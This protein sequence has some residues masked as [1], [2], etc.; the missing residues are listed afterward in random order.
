VSEPVNDKEVSRSFPDGFEWGTAT[1]AHQIEGGNWNND[2]WAW[3]HRPGSGV[4]EPSGDA[5]DSWNRWQEDV[6]IVRNLGLGSYRFSIEWSR[7]E[8]EPGEWSQAALD[9]Y[10]RIGE[11]LRDEGIQPVVT[12]HHFSSPRWFADRG[13]WTAPNAA[14][15]FARFCERAARE[16]API[17]G[18]VCTINEPSVVAIMGYLMGM[19]P[20]GIS[21]EEEWRRVTDS[22]CGAHRKAVD[23]IRSAAPGVP[24][25]MALAMSDYQ[26]LEGGEEKLNEI[27]AMMEDVFLDATEGDDFVGVQ[28]YSR[29]RVGPHGWVGPEPGVPVLPLGYEY[30]PQA[31]AATIRRA[32]QYTGSATPIVVTENGIGSDDDEQ[33]IEYVKVALSGVAD[34][35]DEGID[36]RGYMYWSLLDNFEWTFGYGPKFGLV[37]TDRTTFERRLKPS[38]KFFADVVSRNAIAW[39]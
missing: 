9:H 20:P 22:L 39:R 10:R 2:W 33:R 13:G 34:C 7:I 12:F 32:W 29:E 3:E 1:A 15:T 26:P 4:A 28:T 38:A 24:V 36:V 16:L 21:D 37:E 25:G 17:L 27:R 31:L 8:P 30:Y 6:A 19:F 35:L 23:V 5:C 11:A 18:R 14:D